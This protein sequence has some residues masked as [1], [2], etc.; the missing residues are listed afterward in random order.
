MYNLLFFILL[1]GCSSLEKY[2]TPPRQLI[3]ARDNG[4]SLDRFPIYHAKVPSY[5]QR[6]DP[7]PSESIFDSTKSLCEFI[8]QEDEGQI[9]ITLHNFPTDALEERIPPQA[10]IARWKQQFQQITPS[11]IC[12]TSQSAGGFTGLL[13]EAT[14]TMNG[15]VS[16]THLTLPTIY[17]V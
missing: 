16:Y 4:L 13:L 1:M 8:I 3:A 11:S 17:S 10:Q 6:H 12:L 5:W 7:Q 2:P 15:A 9:R 14:G